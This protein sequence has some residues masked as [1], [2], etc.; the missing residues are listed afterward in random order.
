MPL[1]GSKNDAQP[2]GMS[3]ILVAKGIAIRS[4]DA[5]RGSWHC[6]QATKVAKH[7]PNTASLGLETASDVPVFRG[8]V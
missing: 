3:N 6:H 1:V 4:K 7:I 5:T 8:H 2:L